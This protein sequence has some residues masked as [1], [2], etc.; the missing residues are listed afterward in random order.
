MATYKTIGRFLFTFTAGSATVRCPPGITWADATQ[1]E[2]D[3][4]DAW[5]VALAS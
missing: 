1:N 5:L 3:E 2:R 4:L